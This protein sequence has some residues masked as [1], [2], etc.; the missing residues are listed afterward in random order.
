[1]LQFFFTDELYFL[2]VSIDVTG[3]LNNHNE[4][5]VTVSEGDY[6]ET[7]SDELPPVETMSKEEKEKQDKEKDGNDYY[8]SEHRNWLDGYDENQGI[9]DN[10]KMNFEQ[11]FNP[12]TTNV[13]HHVETSQ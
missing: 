10:G 9:I 4:E 13:P 6:E 2:T 5:S 8:Q 12:L 3:L 7:P 1:M 11:L